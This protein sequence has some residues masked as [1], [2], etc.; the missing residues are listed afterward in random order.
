MSVSNENIDWNEMA[1]LLSP[2]K[3]AKAPTPLKPEV[4]ARIEFNKQTA[5]NRQLAKQLGYP[6]LYVPG[7]LSIV[8]PLP[9]SVS[10]EDQKVMVNR[11]IP[12]DILV[13]IAKNKR[14]AEE[15]MKEA[16]V[17]K[18]EVARRQGIAIKVIEYHE[19]QAE[20]RR[21]ERQEN[22]FAIREQSLNI[23]LESD[24]DEDVEFQKVEFHLSVLER[25]LGLKQAKCI[26]Q[27]TL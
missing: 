27:E 10:A 21:R 4:V 24:T 11:V 16:E 19:S 23:P 20:K 6:N 5:K 1:G 18:T 14:A 17:K 12:Q 8:H 2:L 9:S 22:N 15:R 26:K 3:I 7:H 13:R 25:G